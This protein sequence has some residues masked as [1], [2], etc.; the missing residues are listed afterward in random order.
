MNAAHLLRMG[1]GAMN[2]RRRASI[3]GVVLDLF[4]G[5]TVTR[6]GVKYVQS[7]GD[8][9]VQVASGVRAIENRGDGA[10]D[11]LSMEGSRSNVVRGSTPVSVSGL[12]SN[13]ATPTFAAVDGPLGPMTAATYAFTASTDSRVIYA[14]GS[15]PADNV[16]AH[17][18]CWVRA[19][20]GTQTVRLVMRTKAATYVYSPDFV[21]GTTWTRISWD[22]SVGAGA[23]AP[24]TG[25]ATGSDGLARTVE[26]ACFQA[27]GNSTTTFGFPSSYIANPGT[28]FTTR[29][30]DRLT[31]AVGEYPASFL[32]DGF[33][34]TVRPDGSSSEIVATSSN[35]ALAAI[36]STTY[37]LFQISAGNLRP[38]MVVNNVARITG[39][40]ITFSRGQ[41]VT[42]ALRPSAG[43]L[44]VAGATTGNGLN[45]GTGEAWPSGTLDIGRTSVGGNLNGRIARYMV[46][47]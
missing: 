25:L 42:V 31:Y 36:G 45:T 43:T 2:A 44:T 21:I 9:L 24:T 11:M 39:A 14:W 32:T 29:V 41:A 16:L 38:I 28:S 26:V 33:E 37:L 5:G 17:L 1:A 3:D 12:A 8:S 13:L 34:M 7:D 4:S 15:V 10:G 6:A 23:S 18:S 30:A 46:G 40:N 47:L 35:I 22:V 19:Q 27:E 20:S